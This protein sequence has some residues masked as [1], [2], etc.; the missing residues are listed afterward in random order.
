MKG[1]FIPVA[2]ILFSGIS[3]CS[4]IR[5]QSNLLGGSRQA[6]E[7]VNKSDFELEITA[8]GE[9]V[10]FEVCE[11]TSDRLAPT[12]TAVL[13]FRSP[14]EWGHNTSIT[15]RA[16]KKTCLVEV[17]TGRYYFY[18]CEGRTFVWIVRNED[19]QKPRW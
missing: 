5:V 7:I 13:R 19:F 4:W 9:K 1:F 11:E 15:I 8:N 18:S 16:W 12:Q 14:S 17:I 2:T 6:V 3:G 10:L